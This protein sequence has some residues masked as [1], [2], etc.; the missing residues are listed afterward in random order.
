MERESEALA[1]HLDLSFQ[2]EQ[3]GYLYAKK[4]EKE[5]QEEANKKKTEQETEELAK[6]LQEEENQQYQPKLKPVHQIQDLRG[7]EEH[8]LSTRT[9]RPSHLLLPSSKIS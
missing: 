3:E 5:F 7:S 6:K 4:L 2:Q 9:F 1:Q 8:P